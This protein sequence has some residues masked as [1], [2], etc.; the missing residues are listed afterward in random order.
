MNPADIYQNLCEIFNTRE[1][2]NELFQKLKKLNKSDFKTTIK[3]Y[4]LQFLIDKEDKTAV[5]RNLN[6]IWFLKENIT[7]KDI[8]IKYI[9]LIGEMLKVDSFYKLNIYKDI[10]I[11]MVPSIEEKIS[12]IISI[13]NHL[14]YPELILLLFIGFVLGEKIEF[15]KKNYIRNLK[16]L[17]KTVKSDITNIDSN[18]NII[19]L[20]KNILETLHLYIFFLTN[21]KSDKKSINS[22]K[23]LLISSEVDGFNL[24]EY[25]KKLE[26]FKL[27]DNV[28][29]QNEVD[30]LGSKYKDNILKLLNKIKKEIKDTTIEI[31]IESF[32]EEEPQEESNEEFDSSQKR[33]NIYSLKNFQI[34]NEQNIQII[35]INSKIK[36]DE[37][38]KQKKEFKKNEINDVENGIIENEND[39]KIIKNENIINEE[40][41]K[42]EILDKE[43]KINKKESKLLT[44]KD[45]F[46][47]KCINS[48]NTENQIIEKETAS[49]LSLNSRLSIPVEILVEKINKF[50]DYPP[51]VKQE[52]ITTDENSQSYKDGFYKDI[53]LYFAVTNL[54]Y[55][56]SELNNILNTSV[57][58]INTFAQKF[59][60]ESEIKLLSITNRR[61]EILVNFL[62]DSNIINMKRKLI[63]IIYFHLYLE[64]TECFELN[65]D[66]QPSFQNLDELEKLINL[67]LEKDKNNEK[68]ICDKDI[69]GKYKS[70]IKENKNISPKKSEANCEKKI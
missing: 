25:Y 45:K 55:K 49:F 39:S 7:D 27:L 18:M 41:N 33:N 63:E 24:N 32:N 30:N 26:I 28:F 21:K 36:I 38:K 1:I 22:I 10:E 29:Y 17:L 47:K 5:I 44:K 66:Y 43:N 15:I 14:Y 53:N 59:T 35:N 2:S 67:K 12:L 56:I 9:N 40:S 62:N 31:D 6:D 23:N 54:R 19:S 13:L 46:E 70:L 3:L 37:A 8:I 68:I 60:L 58:D 65:A 48:N 4:L 42:E 57:L 16:D 34:S 69:I 11:L 51:I 52:K 64:N 61:L 50:V 20:D